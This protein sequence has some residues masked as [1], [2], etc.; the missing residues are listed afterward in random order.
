MDKRFKEEQVYARTRILSSI[1]IY[2]KAKSLI[3]LEVPLLDNA[4][5]VHRLT[6]N[7]IKIPTTTGQVKHKHK[8][9]PL[10]GK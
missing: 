1:E 5:L 6:A 2:E 7:V 10:L 9:K 4:D 8:Q 3:F